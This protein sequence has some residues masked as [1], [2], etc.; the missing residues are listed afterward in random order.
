MFLFRFDRPFFGPAA[1]LKGDYKTNCSLSLKRLT[2]VSK[3]I[4]C[5]E[6]MKKLPC[7]RTHAWLIGLYS[8]LS[9]R[10]TGYPA[11][12]SAQTQLANQKP[13][14]GVKTDD[15]IQLPAHLDSSQIDSIVANLNIGPLIAGAGVI[16][17]A[18]GFGAQT[19]VKDI[20]SGLFFLFD[21]AFRVGDYVETAGMKGMVEHI[22]FCYPA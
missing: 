3:I 19:L 21:D 13:A 5:G 8:I 20:I 10:L 1:G 15:A 16:G 18:I 4:S 11:D 12:S 6:S 9:L 14:Q 22:S 17:L 2:P 7:K